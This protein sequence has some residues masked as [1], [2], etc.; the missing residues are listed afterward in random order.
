MSLRS[1]LSQVA[2]LFR[3]MREKYCCQRV[4][5]KALVCLMAVRTVPV[6]PVSVK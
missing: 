1:R 2:V 4:F 6:A 5:D 3:Q